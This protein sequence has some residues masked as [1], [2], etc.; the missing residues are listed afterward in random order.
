V[1]VV[2]VVGRF[3]IY[4]GFQR[5]L[6]LFG[7]QT[8]SGLACGGFG[9]LALAQA[10]VI[11]PGVEQQMQPRHHLFDR[12][13]LAGRTSLAART[14]FAPHAGLA[15]G[16]G[17]APHA[18]L[19]LGTGLAPRPYLALRAHL[20]LRPGLAARTLQTGPPRMALW[21]GTPRLTA[22]A[23]RPLSSLPGSRFVRHLRTLPLI[24]RLFLPDD[25]R[26]QQLRDAQMRIGSTSI[27]P[28]V[29]IRESG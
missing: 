13:Q 6:Y 10:L 11:F 16:T 19:A 24:A 8:F 23:L 22:R 28:T 12:R 20:A 18:G 5:R 7:G 15:L 27:M 9:R 3:A 29:I 17:L 25:R 14:G 21:S 1:V 26:Q 2:L 4:I